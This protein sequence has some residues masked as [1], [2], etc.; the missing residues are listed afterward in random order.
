MLN[1]RNRPILVWN[2]LR[3]SKRWPN[4]HFWVVIW[5]SLQY[6]WALKLLHDILKRQIIISYSGRNWTACKL[7]YPFCGLVKF[8][9]VILVQLCPAGRCHHLRAKS[10][11]L[12]DC[13][14]SWYSYKR[15][16]SL[17][18]SSASLPQYF[19][20]VSY[21][22]CLATL[23]IIA[24]IGIFFLYQASVSFHEHRSHA[25]LNYCSHIDVFVELRETTGALTMKRFLSY[26]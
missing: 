3:A 2:S 6:E 15:P 14:N 10:I 17:L 9:L 12:H 26:F 11:F 21:A 16:P 24:K 25:P 23:N 19:A 18:N 8:W 1:R 5:L 13:C 4:F 22:S 20:K 7:T